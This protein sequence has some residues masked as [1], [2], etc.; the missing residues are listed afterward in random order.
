MQA[1]RPLVGVFNQLT[2][3]AYNPARDLQSCFQ[4]VRTQGGP[5]RMDIGTPSRRGPLPETGMVKPDP[6]RG[7][8]S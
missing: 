4:I 7:E 8:V 5:N 6:S 1:D 2:G 3:P